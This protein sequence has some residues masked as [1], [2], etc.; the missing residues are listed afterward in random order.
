MTGI[1][2]TEESLMVFAQALMD[3]DEGLEGTVTEE[4]D[5]VLPSSGLELIM[6][7]QNAVCAA[8]VLMKAEDSIGKISAD[9]CFK[10]P[11]GI[12]LLIPGQ[13]IT[14]DRLAL[15]GADSVKVVCS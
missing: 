7:V 12:P 13:K 6:S 3:I 1:G 11:P 14:E 10:Y 4:F 2:D 5:C 15:L 8:S 9:Y